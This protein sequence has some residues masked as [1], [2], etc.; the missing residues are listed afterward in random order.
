MTIDEQSMQDQQHIDEQDSIMRARRDIDVER[1]RIEREAAAE[2]SRALDR[3]LE[4]TRFHDELERRRLEANREV[5]EALRVREEERQQDRERFE[6]LMAEEERERVRDEMWA[7]SHEKEGWHGNENVPPPLLPEYER[8]GSFRSINK[9][10]NLPSFEELEKANVSVKTRESAIAI[11]LKKEGKKPELKPKRIK[12]AKP[13]LDI[14]QEFYS[15]A[16]FY[17]YL[18]LPD[19]NIKPGKRIHIGFQGGACML[20]NSVSKAYRFS[21]SVCDENDIFIKDEA[22][23]LCQERF[24][25]AAVVFIKD[26]DEDASFLENV[27]RGFENHFYNLNRESAEPKL[28]VESSKIHVNSLR[29]LYKMIKKYLERGDIYA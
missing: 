8:S 19:K 25:T 1:E 28:F 5:E 17:R 23:R 6:R 15:A 29:E 20:V 14:C 16:F 12:L 3:E 11:K 18:R 9:E 4:E 24:R 2:T 7:H 21:F 27:R 13:I 10:N 22:R 26:V